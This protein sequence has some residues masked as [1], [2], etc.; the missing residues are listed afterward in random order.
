MIIKNTFLRSNLLKPNL[1]KNIKNFS[2]NSNSKLDDE[3]LLG[4]SYK[5]YIYGIGATF[6][7]TSSYLYYKMR[8]KSFY[9]YKPYKSMFEACSLGLISA[10]LWPILF[11]PA[12]VYVSA[13][14]I[15]LLAER[16]DEEYEAKMKRKEK[17]EK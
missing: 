11:F 5:K 6:L 15:V 7:T 13:N 16:L 17:E 8:S 10:P 1:L 4:I 2:S 3:F 12:F 9:K 14:E